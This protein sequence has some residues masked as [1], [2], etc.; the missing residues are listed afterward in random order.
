MVFLQNIGWRDVLDVAIVAVLLYQLLKLIRGTQAVQL[1]VGLGVIVAVG[2]AAEA[3]HL[4]LL[5]FIFANGGQAIVI[6]AVILFQPELRRALDQVGRLGPVRS[7]LGQ[8]AG[9]D[10][11]RTVDEVIRAASSL[12]ERKTGALIV[13][14]RETGLENIATTGVRINGEV[15]AEML[16]TIF[17][18]GTSLHDGAVII[19]E[20]RLVAA[21]CV[22]P[23][24]ET[25]PGVGRMGTRHR[26]AV[27]LTLQS[28]AV[29]LIVSEET[30][31]ISVAHEGRITRGLDAKALRATLM[32]MTGVDAHQRQGIMP[33]PSA[34]RAIRRRTH[35]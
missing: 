12:S 7:L 21:G 24:A 23:L 35:S 4:R 27:G 16:A 28:D 17:L 5:Q 6:A 30:G 8:H 2:L 13:F 10:A 9:A 34:L 11:Q 3:L 18:P 15:T 32:T 25:I 19:H 22:L 33:R 31:L 20:S 29:V 14:E 1:L 26:A